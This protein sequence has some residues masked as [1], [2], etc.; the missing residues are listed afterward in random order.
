MAGHFLQV[1]GALAAVAGVG[2]AVKKHH[3]NS[4]EEV[5]DPFDSSIKVYQRTSRSSRALVSKV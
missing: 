4:E 5:S 3:D 2:Y 1:G